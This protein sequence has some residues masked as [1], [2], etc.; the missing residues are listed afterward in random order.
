L[1]T[2][3]SKLIGLARKHP[4][5]PLAVKAAAAATIAWALVQPL[6]GTADQYPYY[7]P[8][9]A[10]IAVSTTV[11]GSVRASVQGVLA[12]FVGAG[13]ALVGT[14]LPLPEVAVLAVVVALGTAV[15]GWRGLG[16]M[17]SW[18]PI[19]ALFVLIV[20][21][22]DPVAYAV[23]YLALTGLGAVVGV[24]VN[25]LAPPLPLTAASVRE[26]ALRDSV[27]SQLM[28]LADGL[29]AGQLLS[30][31]EWRDRLLAL[32]P[33]AD[34]LKQMVSE[35]TEARRIN[36]RARRWKVQ[37]EHQYERS[38]ALEQLSSLVEDIGALVVA[39]EHAD[40]REVALGPRLRPSAARA[41]SEVG[42]L[43]C[44]ADGAG[45]AG[46]EVADAERALRNLEEEVRDHRVQTSDDLF[47]ACSI[48]VALRRALTALTQQLEDAS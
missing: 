44:A 41:L 14:H 19:S 25:M 47:T 30:D 26:Q 23:T 46:P 18:V 3:R 42:T 20:G 43:L 6:G 8:L 2:A 24:L 40:L 7:A 32:G 38:R 10:V 31:H 15:A 13:L 22:T 1:T 4:R 16:A 9:G 29:A 39:Q 45:E 35:A 34:Q 17:A 21:E 11:A 12:I 28:A 5:L 36:W 27:A 37:A 48:V 33:P